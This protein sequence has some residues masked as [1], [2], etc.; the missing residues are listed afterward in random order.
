MGKTS[1]SD[2]EPGVVEETIR[3]KEQPGNEIDLEPSA[4][5]AGR[6]EATQRQLSPTDQSL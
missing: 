3:S 4:T 2:P 5:I 6:Q 1:T